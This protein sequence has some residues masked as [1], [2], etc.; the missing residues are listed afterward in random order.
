LNQR[1]Y[2]LGQYGLGDA[3]RVRIVNNVINF[4]QQRRIVQIKV[5]VNGTGKETIVLT[6]NYPRPEQMT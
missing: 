5:D 1:A 3:V 4:D 6:T 2:P